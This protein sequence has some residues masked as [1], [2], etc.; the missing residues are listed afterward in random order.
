M[1][2]LSL[3][4]DREPKVFASVGQCSVGEAREEGRAELDLAGRLDTPAARPAGAA[5][6]SA[7]RAS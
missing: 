4:K 1:E 5:S 7:R 2:T 3:S 6:R